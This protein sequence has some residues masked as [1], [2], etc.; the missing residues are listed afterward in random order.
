MRIK[1]ILTGSLL[2]LSLLAVSVPVAAQVSEQEKQEKEA[3]RK[4]QLERK[5]YALV[6]E[7]AA[8][9]LSLKLPEN[10]SYVLAA[11][12]DLLW[13]H[14]QP[15]A[16]NLFWYATTT[17]NLLNNLAGNDPSGQASKGPK[18]TAKESEKSINEY[19][20]FFGLRQELLQR[21][22][23]RDP[24]FALEILRSTR[25]L[26]F[27]APAEWTSQGYSF[28]DDHMLEQEIATQAATRDP[29]KALA[30]ARE[31]LAKGF[32][33]QL[34]QFLYTLNQQD[35]E[36]ATKFA[37]EMIDKLHG[38]NIGT[39]SQATQ[40]AISLLTM[41]RTPVGGS[42][43]L[44][45]FPPLKLAQEQ[46]RDLIEMITNAALTESANGNL[47]FDLST[48]RPEIREFAPERLAPIER[49]LA[50]FSQT[51]NKNQRLSKDYN[52][53]FDKGSPEEL[54]KFATKAGSEHREMAQQAI[55]LAVV[56][57]RADSMREFITT[58]ITDDA[59]RKSLLDALDTQEIDFAI[60]RGDTETIEKV[61]PRVRRPEER[62]RA[63]SE[64]A[65]T[66]EKRGDHDEALKMLDEAQTLIK[67]DFDSRT[68]T[69]ALLALVS[70]YA[71]VEPTRAFA[72][73]ERTIDRANDDMTKILLLDKLVRT[74]V[75]KKGEL[76][77]RQMGA[78]PIDYSVFK[79][80]KS[81]TA[82]AN[83]DF[84]RTRAAADRFERNELRL[85]A[86]LVLAQSLLRK[87]PAALVKGTNNSEASK[88]Q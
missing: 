37:G 26:S 27:E 9:A 88:N 16:R 6:D 28:P 54:L 42:A 84:D 33:F 77:M 4:Q 70:A 48:I 69:N 35:G 12:A 75:V 80:G 73:I 13:E 78:I 66:L 43:T 51:L 2:C 79:Y 46:R 62:A 85:M 30:L 61:L 36:L 74:G 71:L 63:M 72:I 68:Q 53:L 14:D 24:Q 25:Q 56:R 19:M 20:S 57:K 44:S 83:V 64:I 41:S 1:A 7:I 45:A 50:A 87:E 39:D 8:A 40:I 76:T 34:F 32:S 23:R 86:R 82:L 15:R 67:T 10:R 3:E 49:K 29:Q 58:E 52:D 38:R 55:E 5:T 31:S 59:Q 81:V 47:L 65:V 18:P 60:E 11:A 22:A 21:I 17:L